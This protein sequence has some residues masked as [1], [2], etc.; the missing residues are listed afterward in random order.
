MIAPKPSRERRLDEVKD[1]VEA[2]WHDDQVAERLTAVA[3]EMLDKLKAG[4]PLA[5]AAA[6]HG[7]TAAAAFGL[8]RGRAADPLSAKGA[9]TIF[10]LPKGGSGFAE[11]RT[12]AA[13]FVAPVTDIAAP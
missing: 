8:K 6:A 7:V 13:R 9:D 3:T 4:T 12:P 10:P 1:R 11:V 5:D 2:R